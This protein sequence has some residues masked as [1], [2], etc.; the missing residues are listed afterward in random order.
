MDDWATAQTVTVKAGHDDDTVGDTATL[1]HTASG[2]DYTGITADLPVTVT[3]AGDPHV[4]VQFGAN[5]YT[6]SEGSTTTITVTL[7]A[8]PKRATVVIP[9][10]EKLLQGDTTSADYSVQPSVTFNSGRPR[11]PLT[12]QQCR[13]TW[14][15]TTRA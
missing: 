12:S 13:T 6:V 7:S 15:T 4:T 5:A 2:G 1:T 8:D 9:F 3:D 11:R 10:V 14:T